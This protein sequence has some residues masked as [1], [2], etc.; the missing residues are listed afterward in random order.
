MRQKTYGLV[1]PIGNQRKQILY[2]SRMYWNGVESPPYKNTKSRVFPD[3]QI[4][5]E[6][7]YETGNTLEPS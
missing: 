5:L 3:Y 1:F 2:V 4:I 6:V 7:N